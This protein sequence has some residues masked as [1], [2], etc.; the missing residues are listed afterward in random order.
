MKRLLFLFL[1]FSN[2]SFSQVPYNVVDKMNKLWKS[3]PEFIDSAA[4]NIVYLSDGTQMI[5]DDG[6]KKD[7]VGL[8][9]HP[10]LEDIFAYPYTAGREWESPPPVDFDPGRIRVEEFFKK[11]YGSTADEV[12]ANLVTIKWMPK[13]TK[14]SVK[15][16]K[17]NGVDKALEKVSEE[18]DNLP[19]EFKKY[20][21]KTAGTFNWRVIAGTDKL[22]MHS[23]GI[24]IDINT[25]YSDYWQWNK[26]MKYVN[27]IPFE[28]VEIFEKHGF[29]WGGKWYHYDTMHFE[30]RPELLP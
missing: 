8:F 27:K 10:D 25:K 20:V 13:S 5:F 22:S 17:I 16:T 2:F 19:Q 6:D 12:E 18:L 28:I 24:A 14:S 21:T 9:D 7:F 1:L 30:Y 11:M 4:N 29:I 23:Y 3:Y 15:I 26:D